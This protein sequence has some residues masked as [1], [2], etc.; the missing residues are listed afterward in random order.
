MVKTREKEERGK[1]IKKWIRERGKLRTA[2]TK[3]YKPIHRQLELVWALMRAAEC[4]SYE[5]Q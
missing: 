3:A 2:H 4:F 5:D 1:E